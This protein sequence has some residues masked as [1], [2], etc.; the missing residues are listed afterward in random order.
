MLVCMH[1]RVLTGHCAGAGGAHKEHVVHIR[2]PRSVEAERLV[3][4]RTLE[5]ALHVCDAGRVEAQ[6][7]VKRRRALPRVERRA[8]GAGRAAG[9]EAEDGGRRRC[10]GGLDL[11]AHWPSPSVYITP[12]QNCYDG[13]PSAVAGHA[14]ACQVDLAAIKLVG[15]GSNARH[16]SCYTIFRGRGPKASSRLHSQQRRRPRC[17]PTRNGWTRPAATSQSRT[18]LV[19]NISIASRCISICIGI[20]LS[21]LLHAV[22][23]DDAHH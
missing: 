8:Y 7:L 23:R 18:H 19:V 1:T 21:P 13:H 16:L 22:E 14:V 5:H 6:R 11:L 15:G 12:V 20:C 4:S 10:R 17:P 3:E 2:N 9:R